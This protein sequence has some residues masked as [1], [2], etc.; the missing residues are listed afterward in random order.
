MPITSLFPRSRDARP[1]Q[2]ESGAEAMERVRAL[3][4]EYLAAVRANDAAWFDRHLAEDAVVLLAG[5][6][7]LRKPEF[8]GS[9][10]DAPRRFR[11]LE[12]RNL[13]VRWFGATIQVDADAPWELADG[14]RGVSRYL[15]TYAWLDGR[16][17]VISAQIT[18]LAPDATPR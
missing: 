8:L 15:D 12:A 11:S 1:A 6:R 14:S 9:L 3:N 17:Q 16:W 7:R 10:R 5:G 18:P 4:H 2:S 13:T